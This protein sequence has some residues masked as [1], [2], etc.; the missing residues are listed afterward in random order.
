MECYHKTSTIGRWALF[1]HH[2]QLSLL[3]VLPDSVLARLL[4]Q[5]L[6]RL[7][8]FVPRLLL[9]GHILPGG[10]LVSGRLLPTT[11]LLVIVQSPK[12]D[13]PFLVQFYDLSVFE[14]EFSRYILTAIVGRLVDVDLVGNGKRVS[15]SEKQKWN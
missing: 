15:N 12:G 1:R 5:H 11:G 2:L 14:S 9:G 6:Q 8:Q 4:A 7:V 10:Q 3:L 13:E